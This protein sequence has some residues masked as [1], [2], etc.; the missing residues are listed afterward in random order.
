MDMVCMVDDYSYT[1]DFVHYKTW[2]EILFV[3]WKN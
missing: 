3:L 1:F 2:S